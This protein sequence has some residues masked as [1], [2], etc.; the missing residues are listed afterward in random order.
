MYIYIKLSP[1]YQLIL[2]YSKIEVSKVSTIYLYFAKSI[3]KLYKISNII[4][5]SIQNYKA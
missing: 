1:I 5:E 4:T 3:Y 2:Y